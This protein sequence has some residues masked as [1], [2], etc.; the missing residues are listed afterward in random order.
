METTM[1]NVLFVCTANR[2]RSPMAERLFIRQLEPFKEEGS[3]NWSIS[4]DGTWAAED[5]PPDINL[6]KA[7]ADFQIDI[8]DHPSTAIDDALLAQQDLILVMDH[9]H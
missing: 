3:R 4:S 6:I 8:R 9:N 1:P 2:C 5:I 7:M